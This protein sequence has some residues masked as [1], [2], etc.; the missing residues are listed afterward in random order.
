M[1]IQQK[2]R[3]RLSFNPIVHIDPIGTI[4]LPGLLFATGAPFIL[5][6]A[7]PVPVNIRRVI[8]NKGIK[9]AIEVTLAGVAYNFA[10]AALATVIFYT[11][12]KP[13]SLVGGFFVLLIIQSVIINVVLGFLT[14]GLYRH[15]MVHKHSNTLR[16]I[17]VGIRSLNF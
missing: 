12:D 16:H 1:I 17:C 5:G 11:L 3:G 9:G 15:S 6:W 7:K 8:Q 2:M 10:L 4:L 13:T 14:F